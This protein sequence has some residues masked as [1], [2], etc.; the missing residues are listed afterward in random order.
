MS[1]L[2]TFTRFLPDV[3]PPARCHVSLDS[4]CQELSK[5]I[6]HVVCRFVA[7]WHDALD[8]FV[9]FVVFGLWSASISSALLFRFC[10]W[11]RW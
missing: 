5:D 1:T 11:R 10:N 4:A 6:C 8:F 9:V 3:G 2:A 7:A